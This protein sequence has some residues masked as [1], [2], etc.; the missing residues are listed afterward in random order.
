MRYSGAHREDVRAVIH[1]LHPEL[2]RVIDE[3]KAAQNATV[4][5]T[6]AVE[7]F[8]KAE[9]SVPK[10]TLIEDRSSPPRVEAAT[11]ASTMWV[12]PE[13]PYG[14]VLTRR[15]TREIRRERRYAEDRLTDGLKVLGLYRSMRL[16]RI[17]YQDYLDA[18]SQEHFEDALCFA[19]S[20]SLKAFED[21]YSVVEDSRK[22]VL[23]RHL[24]WGKGNDA[25]SA[26]RIYYAWDQHTKQVI[27]GSAPRHLPIWARS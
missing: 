9:A 4:K 12:P 3:A 25:I 21:D 17:S 13:A 18:A 10:S 8:N 1:F 6:S 7:T 20:G 2:K 11:V 24:K 15:V 26:I 16:G 23:D 14:V 5:K 19:D 22:Y 27:V